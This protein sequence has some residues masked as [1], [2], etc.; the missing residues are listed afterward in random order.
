MKNLKV[1]PL[2]DAI[3]QFEHWRASRTKHGPIPTELLEL[4]KSLKTQYRTTHI[5]HA[6]K[7]NGT[8]LK[9]SRAKTHVPSVPFM[10][11]S[12][13]GPL[14]LTSSQG[15]S[16]SF[17]SKKGLPITLNGLQARDIPI[18]I[19]AFLGDVPCFN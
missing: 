1:D 15:I 8:R 14:A 5:A 3:K 10:E 4:A 11:C 6:L 12:M 7:I 2:A 19:T 18:L 16:L 9:E 17:H 13:Q